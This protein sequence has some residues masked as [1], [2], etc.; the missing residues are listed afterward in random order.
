V[1]QIKFNVKLKHA[2]KAGRKPDQ[3]FSIK[4]NKC[5][6]NLKRGQAEDRRNTAL[7]RD[8]GWKPASY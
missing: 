4:D 8:A 1:I 5:N 6:N 7:Q 2:L 3:D